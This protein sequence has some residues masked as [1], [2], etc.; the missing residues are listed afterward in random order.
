MLQR[1]SNLRKRRL[2]SS[3]KNS[4][5]T[6][7]PTELKGKLIWQKGEKSRLKRSRERRIRRE[8]TKMKRVRKRR[9]M[10]MRMMND[11]FQAHFF[12]LVYKPLYTTYFLKKK[13]ELK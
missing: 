5:G 13:K 8:M 10:K 11:F 6:L 2:L 4:K 1:A 12:F 3:R 9:K 7:L